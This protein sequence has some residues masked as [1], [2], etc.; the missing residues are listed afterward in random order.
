MITQ[1]L[2]K[3]SKKG[4][5]K[6][7]G[8]NRETSPAHI[9]KLKKS[10]EQ[11]GMV[12]AI[13]VA[14]LNFITGKNELYIID[15]QHKYEACLALGIDIPYVVIDT[16][17]N[18]EELVT[19]IALLNSSS[20]PWSMHDYVVAWGSINNDYKKLNYYHNHYGVE[21]S[22]TA[23]ILSELGNYIGINLNNL[24]K[25]GEFK[26]VNEE[27]NKV[28]IQNLSELLKQLPAKIQRD[29]LKSFFSE[30]VSMIRDL[31]KRYD[32]ARMLAYVRKQ[33]DNIFKFQ[34][35]ED[36]RNF[37][38]EYKDFIIKEPVLVVA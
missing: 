25:S 18:Y 36:V 10:I 24:I 28:I 35:S 15:G 17:T 19:T 1:T 22:V 21:L 5:K 26:I 34:S 9:A 16:I 12:Q 38:A 13:I 14:E 2:K 6:L 27:K 3:D 33:K 8:I 11:I 7:A 37:I 4:F 23:M 31:D 29:I 20:K 32:H 30:F